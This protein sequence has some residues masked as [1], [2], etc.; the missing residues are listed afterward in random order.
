VKKEVALMVINILEENVMKYTLEKMKVVV[1]K[2]V[3]CIWENFGTPVKIEIGEIDF[4]WNFD[5]N[6][7]LSVL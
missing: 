6:S 3:V 5:K 7:Y 4:S 1:E 2:E